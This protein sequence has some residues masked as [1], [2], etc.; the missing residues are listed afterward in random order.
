VI[1]V[2]LGGTWGHPIRIR[3]IIIGVGRRIDGLIAIVDL[4]G[5]YESTLPTCWP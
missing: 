2:D 1:R 3:R 5:Q 4:S